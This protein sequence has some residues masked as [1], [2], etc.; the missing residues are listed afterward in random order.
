MAIEPGNEELPRLIIGSFVETKIQ[1]K[2]LDEV[3]KVKRDYIRSNE[4]IWVME[5]DSL[6]IRDIEI[7]FQDSEYAYVSAGLDNGDQVVTT[8][9]ANVTQG[10]TLRLEGETSA[11][12][13]NGAGE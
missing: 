6:K 11:P 5:G 10:A 13:T 7:Q 4:S 9:L 12:D 3:V 1:G 8:N 2:A